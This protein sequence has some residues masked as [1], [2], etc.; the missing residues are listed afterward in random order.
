MASVGKKRQE[1]TN[2]NTTL[3]KRSI[4]ELIKVVFKEECLKQH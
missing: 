1:S 4:V 2:E 3:D